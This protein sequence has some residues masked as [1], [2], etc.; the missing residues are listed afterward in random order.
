[1]L[2][3]VAANLF[4]NNPGLPE[5]GSSQVCRFARSQAK[6]DARANGES[7]SSA[8]LLVSS[9][10]FFFFFFCFFSFF[11]LFGFDLQE[12]EIRHRMRLVGG[13]GVDVY[14]TR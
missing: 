4:T 11:Q 2:V 6:A 7:V 13:A 14:E 1:M 9:F 10:L 3:V 12:I 8:Y 5:G